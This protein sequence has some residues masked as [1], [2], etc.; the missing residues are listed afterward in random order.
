MIFDDFVCKNNQKPL[1]DYFI[2]GRHKNCSVIYLFQ[3]CYKTPKDIRLNCSHFGIYEFP[4]NDEVSMICRENNVDKENTER[5][6][7]ILSLFCLLT[8]RGSSFPKILIKI[9]SYS[10]GLLSGSSSQSTQGKQGL[11]GVGFKLTF[12]GDYDLDNKK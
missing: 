12:S 6:R 11:P 8:N 1:V 5:L 4:S 7:K 3:S 2:R 9:M 10:N